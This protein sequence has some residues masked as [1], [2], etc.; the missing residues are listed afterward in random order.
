MP[1]ANDS[2]KSTGKSIVLADDDSLILEAIGEILRAKG[3]VVHTAQDG[4]EALALIWAVKPDY[5][6]LDVVL[7]KLDGGRVCAAVRQN[8]QLRHT[9]I[10]AYSSLSPQDYHFFPQLSADAY[11]AKGPLATAA[12]NIVAAINHLDEMGL[13]GVEGQRLGYENYRPRRLV[14]ELLRERSHLASVLRVAAPYTME[15]DRDGRIVMANPGVCEILGKREGELVGNP[16]TSL[17]PDAHKS[18]V[19]DLLN[20]LLQ[21]TDAMQ[22]IIA[23]PLGSTEMVPVRLAPVLEENA[24]VGI[25]AMM[26]GVKVSKPKKDS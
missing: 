2:A 12:L 16:F 25:L 15:L 7:P 5:I 18:V 9:P 26:Q 6:I 10:I 4:L 24:C 22:Q 23:L 19:Q 21:S 3:Y 14:E 17:L 8:A 1:E 13:E 20:T 11:V